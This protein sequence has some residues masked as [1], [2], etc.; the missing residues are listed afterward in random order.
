LIREV[1][2]SNQS[3]HQKVRLF[4][5]SVAESLRDD[6]LF[7]YGRTANFNSEHDK[8]DVCITLDPL[9]GIEDPTRNFVTN[10]PIRLFVY[11]QTERDDREEQYVPAL[12]DT[13]YIAE[14][15]TRKLHRS[16]EE[17]DTSDTGEIV[18]DRIAIGPIQKN[19]AIQVLADCLT[20]WTLAF[21]MEVPDT[22]DYCEHYDS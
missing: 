10:Y 19:A 2:L 7:F 18:T 8:P 20:G 1:E 5:K 3:Q 4:I 17:E 11:K 9:N 12:D 21:N 6:L 16:I 22:F 15:F 14:L 13:A